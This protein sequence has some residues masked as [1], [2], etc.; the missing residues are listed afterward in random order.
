MFVIAVTLTLCPFEAIL[1]RQYMDFPSF[2]LTFCPFFDIGPL[3]FCSA[4][5][6]GVESLGWN[7]AQKMTRNGRRG[8]L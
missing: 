7:G 3:Y 8:V 4:L 2:Y 5:C 6:G 1:R